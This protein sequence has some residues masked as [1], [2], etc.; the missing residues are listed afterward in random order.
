V[1]LFG[2][3]QPWPGT[4]RVGGWLRGEFRGRGLMTAA[5]RM[6]AEWAFAELKLEGLQMCFER[7]NEASR[8]VT[9]KVGAQRSGW[10]QGGRS[11]T[12]IVLERHTLRP[13]ATTA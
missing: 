7:D 2:F 8:R 13:P 3:D 11:R 9:E 10:A 6:L 5:I 1:W 12:P 4:A